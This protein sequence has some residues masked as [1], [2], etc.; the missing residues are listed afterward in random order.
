M[1][2]VRGLSARACSRRRAS[3]CACLACGGRS[4]MRCTAWRTATTTSAPGLGSPLPHRRRD[5]AAQ[6]SRS[7]LRPRRWARPILPSSR[8]HGTRP[9]AGFFLRRPRRRWLNLSLCRPSMPLRSGAGDHSGHGLRSSL[10]PSASPLQTNAPCSGGPGR[11][12]RALHFTSAV[13]A[14]TGSWLL[15]GRLIQQRTISSTT[16]HHAAARRN[17]RRPDCHLFP[18]RS[19]Q[20][21]EAWHVQPGG[22]MARQSPESLARAIMSRWFSCTRTPEGQPPVDM[23]QVSVDCELIE[24]YG[25][26]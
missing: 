24:R 8:V 21:L 11:C 6:L 13:R 9:L 18:T 5:W 22:E 1:P 3:A 12:L 16:E 2:T 14:L 17:A 25:P 23:G 26:G 19:C 7:P 10:S 15:L 4:W 20:G